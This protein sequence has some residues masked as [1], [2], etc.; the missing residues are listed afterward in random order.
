MG[1]AACAAVII[2]SGNRLTAAQT[3]LTYDTQNPGV[4]P[5][6]DIAD[7]EAAI[8]DLPGTAEWIN[9]DS[10]LKTVQNSIPT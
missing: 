5:A 8:L 6:Q 2:D 4:I 9:F 7:L 10:T 1:N 3:A